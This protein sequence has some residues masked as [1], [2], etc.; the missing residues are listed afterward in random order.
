LKETTAEVIYDPNA[1]A[2][3]ARRHPKTVLRALRRGQLLGYQSGPGCGWRIFESDLEAWIRGEK[4]ARK[5][6][7]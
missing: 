6:A 1:A 2:E 7:A 3:R 5:Q 4:P